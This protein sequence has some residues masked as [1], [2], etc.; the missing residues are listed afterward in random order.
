[1]T[2][3]FMNCLY[4]AGINTAY[5]GQNVF[6][7][8]NSYVG[9]PNGTDQD[10]TIAMFTEGWD[11]FNWHIDPLPLMPPAQQLVNNPATTISPVPTIEIPA[12]PPPKPST[13][14]FK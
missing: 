5:T 9:L 3:Y 8:W 10:R 2:G 4:N 11:W 12:T 14:P 6:K 13:P 7:K 1:M